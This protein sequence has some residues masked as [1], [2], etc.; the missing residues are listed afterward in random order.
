M[1]QSE[2]NSC[3]AVYAKY[4]YNMGI[5]M[6]V[7]EWQDVRRDRVPEWDN[8]LSHDLDQGKHNW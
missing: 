6:A 2:N 3:Q 8:R 5:V 7:I 4:N 1:Q